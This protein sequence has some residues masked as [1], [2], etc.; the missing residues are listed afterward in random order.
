MI[1]DFTVR[2]ITNQDATAF[3]ETNEAMVALYKQFETA[4]E[5]DDRQNALELL[6]NVLESVGPKD[7]YTVKTFATL[8]R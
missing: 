6:L 4:P 5:E 2:I 3:A 1:L 8:Q 7:E